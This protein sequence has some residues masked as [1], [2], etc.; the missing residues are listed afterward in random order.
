M[1]ISETGY[2]FAHDRMLCSE[3]PGSVVV[4]EPKA[5]SKPIFHIDARPWVF[6]CFT[7]ALLLFFNSRPWLAH[8]GFCFTVAFASGCFSLRHPDLEG[9]LLASWTPGLRAGLVGDRPG[10]LRSLGKGKTTQTN[11]K[12]SPAKQAKARRK[13]YAGKARIAGMIED[14]SIG[15]MSFHRKLT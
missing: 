14:S 2:G 15:S 13:S 12:G 9:G 11:P 3:R 5:G 6:F 7:I 10:K 1:N 8:P 4:Q